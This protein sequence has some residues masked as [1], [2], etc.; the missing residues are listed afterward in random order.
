MTSKPTSKKITVKITLFPPFSKKTSKE[1][2][3][4]S[5]AKN[6]TVKDLL[7]FLVRKDDHIKKHLG[8]MTREEDVRLHALI[9]HN[10]HLARLDKIIQDGDRFNLLQ[11]LQGG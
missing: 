1:Q 3:T 6:S 4:I 7:E 10:D 5:V 2:V 11:P 9:T 8:D